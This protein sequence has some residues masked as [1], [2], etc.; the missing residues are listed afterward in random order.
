MSQVTFSQVTSL[1]SLTIALTVSSTIVP[2]AAKAFEVKN[3]TF[4]GQQ[5]IP[6]NAPVAGNPPTTLNGLSGL[7]YAGNDTYYAISD[8]AGTDR[9]STR[10]NSSHV[11]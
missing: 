1:C 7:T 3:A 4:I 2:Q 5:T 8:N 9:K 11:D 10:L 6:N